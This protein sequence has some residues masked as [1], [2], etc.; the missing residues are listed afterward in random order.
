M[1]KKRH[2]SDSYQIKYLKLETSGG[3]GDFASETGDY[4]EVFFGG[5]GGGGRGGRRDLK[6]EFFLSLKIHKRFV[7][8]LKKRYNFLA[9][10]LVTQNLEKKKNLI[11]K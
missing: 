8:R 1:F 11:D 4:T 3:C 7:V 6:V 5:K 10:H 9:L 2:N